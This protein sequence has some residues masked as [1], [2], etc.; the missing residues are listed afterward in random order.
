MPE[1]DKNTLARLIEKVKALDSQDQEIF[2][3]M[4]SA[5]QAG[6]DAATAAQ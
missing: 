4:L 6:K 1:H 5:Y 2:I 3:L